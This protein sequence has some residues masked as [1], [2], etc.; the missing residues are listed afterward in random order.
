[1]KLFDKIKDLFTDEIIEE[2]EE[3]IEIKEE[4]KEERKLPKIMR[5]TKE[6]K[7]E[8]IHSTISDKDLFKDFG[9]LEIENNNINNNNDINSNFRFP[10]SFE[11]ND[12]L[13]EKILSNQ[14][15]MHREQ[16]KEVEKKVVPPVEIYPTKQKKEEEV[17]FFKVSPEISPE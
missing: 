13:D 3:I 14:N 8:I 12:L 7:D 10:I 16:H 17:K 6:E 1:M 15:I 4:K 2:K 9:N 11:D 5:E